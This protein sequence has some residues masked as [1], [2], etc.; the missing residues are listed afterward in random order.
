MDTFLLQKINAL[1]EDRW[2][3]F[4]HLQ[5]GINMTPSSTWYA[6]EIHKC[7]GGCSLT[8][9]SLYFPACNM[10]IAT[11][12]GCIGCQVKWHL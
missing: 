8:S 12:K 5:I 3:S 11:L 9:L 7:Q 2:L 10:K 6:R 4:S 1:Q